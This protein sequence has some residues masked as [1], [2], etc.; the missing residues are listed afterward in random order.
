MT[1]KLSFW[2]FEWHYYIKQKK[3]CWKECNF[4]FAKLNLFNTH[5]KRQH[6]LALGRHRNTLFGQLNWWN[7]PRVRKENLY[8]I[9]AI[10]YLYNQTLL[11]HKWNDNVVLRW[12][13]KQSLFLGNCIDEANN[14]RQR[15]IAINAIFH[16]WN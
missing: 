10:L 11:I 13:D 6:Y 5:M 12:K 16:L 7:Q 4:T 14:M 15:Q 2:T 1:S 9:N 8:A 3:I